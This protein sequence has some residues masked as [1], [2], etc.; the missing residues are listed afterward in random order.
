MTKQINVA[1]SVSI[2]IISIVVTLTLAVVTVGYFSVKKVLATNTEELI[3]IEMNTIENLLDNYL[4]NHIQLIKDRAAI[5]IIVAASMNG[6]L[7]SRE[8]ALLKDQLSELLVFGKRANYALL[9]IE[10]EMIVETVHGML[11]PDVVKTAAEDI[12]LEK[13]EGFIYFIEKEGNTVSIL[14]VVP[15][16]YNGYPEGVLVAEVPESLSEVIASGDQNNN[17]EI[18]ILQQSRKVFSLG[19]DS[20]EHYIEK[21]FEIPLSVSYFHLK[22]ET[23]PYINSINA[24]VVNVALLAFAVMI[25]FLV[26]F[27]F[28]AE[29]IIV[30]PSQ[31]IKEEEQKANMLNEQLTKVNEDLSQFAYI[32]SHDLKS[33]LMAIG[34]LAGWVGED[35][36]EILP[37]DSK[38]HLKL[39]RQR[40]VRM[41]KLLDDLLEYSRI[42]RFDYKYEEIDILDLAKTHFEL[43]AESKSFNLSTSENR[44]VWK[45]PRTP[46]E[47]VLR[48]LISNSIKHHDRGEGVIQV[49]CEENEREY[50]LTVQ[51]DG[52]G[53]KPGLHEKALEMFQTLR[54]RDEVEGSGMGLSLVKKLVESFHGRV[55]LVSPDQGGLRVNTYWPKSMG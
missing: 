36:E 41:Q 47:I 49:L 52:P 12:L 54:S 5:P 25:F 1:T 22:F 21:T 19:R 33:P 20:F 30:E 23:T 10:S 32:A 27:R 18:S 44:V 42:G 7:Q 24:L 29:K 35:C 51:D 38:K 50:I 11:I 8:Q 16:V 46:V 3:D 4:D 34:Q 53:I 14:Y 37:D 2:F 26:V 45:L 28:V 6:S 43:I 40:V 17:L 31:R 9:N 55:E 13:I 39:M 15:V 48:N